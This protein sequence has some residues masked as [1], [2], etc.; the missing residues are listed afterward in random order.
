[1]LFDMY[2]P[3]KVK[4]AVSGCPRNCAEAGIKDVGVIGVDSGYELYVGGNGG[5]KTEVAQF[6]VKVKSDEE[7]LE[8]AGAFLQLYREEGFYLER[9]C[10]WLERVGLEHAKNRVVEDEENRKAL[11]ARLLA[12]LQDAPGSLGRARRRCRAQ[13]IRNAIIV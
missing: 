8:Y 2:S 12:E 3:H 5:I 13:R 11:H 6:L 9:T 7:V 1:M 10:H 4:L